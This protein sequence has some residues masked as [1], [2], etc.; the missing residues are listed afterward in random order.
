MEKE[1]EASPGASVL[2]ML[3]TGGFSKSHF[4]P[5]YDAARIHIQNRPS[6]RRPKWWTARR[7]FKTIRAESQPFPVRYPS[8]VLNKSAASFHTE[9]TAGRARE[10]KMKDKR[11]KERRENHL[12]ARL[13][14]CDPYIDADFRQLQ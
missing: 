14:E 3:F 12:E 8:P 1:T 4:M 10:G 11:R 5:A 2:K 9:F 7:C 6:R 13:C